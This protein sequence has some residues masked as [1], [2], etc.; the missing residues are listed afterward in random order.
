VAVTPDKDA[1]AALDEEKLY[2]PDAAGV[3]VGEVRSKDPSPRVLFTP[4]HEN[5]G[6][7]FGKGFIL[8]VVA[9]CVI[10]AFPHGSNV[11]FTKSILAGDAETALIFS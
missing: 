8:E 5:V 3:E 4:D 11:A 6:I 2:V 10:E 7:I 1:T 9:V